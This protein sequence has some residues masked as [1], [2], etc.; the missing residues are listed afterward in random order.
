MDNMYSPIIRALWNYTPT[1]QFEKQ[2]E[3]FIDNFIVNP[4]PQDTIR[5]IILQ[6]PYL[7]NNFTFFINNPAYDNYYTY[8]FTY[9]KNILA[10]HPKAKLFLGING[11]VKDFNIEKKFGVSTLIGG[12][13][14]PNLEGYKLRHEIYNRENEIQIPKDIYLS[15]HY[16]LNVDYSN[17]LILYDDK[18]IMFDNQ[19]HVTIENTSMDNMFTEKLIDCFQSKT[20][21]IYYGCPNIGEYFNTNGIIQINSITEAISEINKL[22]PEYY[23]EK[24]EYIEENYNK[25]MKYL[26]YDNLLYN[27]INEMLNES[28]ENNAL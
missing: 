4:I 1:F 25:S 15:S 6:E 2:V 18:S 16:K 22:T 13:S 8:I 11:W 12:K 14:S 20:I 21:P 3:I 10:T 19:F 26:S 9:D 23:L 5:I 27:K 17:K 7:I 28:R 24:L